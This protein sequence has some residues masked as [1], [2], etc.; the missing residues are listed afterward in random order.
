MVTHKFIDD[1][2][3][4]EGPICRLGQIDDMYFW[5]YVDFEDEHDPYFIITDTEHLNDSTKAAHISMIEP[6]YLMFKKSPWKHWKLTSEE[7][8]TL[9]KY[10]K[11][12]VY[13]HYFVSNWQ[14]FLFKWTW[15]ANT[16][17]MNLDNIPG[18][19]FV[20]YLDPVEAY[21]DH[22]FDKCEEIQESVFLDPDLA[23]PD[24]TKLM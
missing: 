9:L 23:I 6:V 4:L 21:V 20:K 7:L 15:E 19:Y 11:Q 22:F 1:S 2:E 8:N 16:V 5:M 13:Q 10:L 3:Y 24:Y 14:Y 18:Y 17:L 12:I